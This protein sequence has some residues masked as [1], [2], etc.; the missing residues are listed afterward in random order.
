MKY[1]VTCTDFYLQVYSLAVKKCGLIAY[2][3]KR[4]LLADLNNGQPNPNTHA[5]GHYSQVNEVQVEDAEEQAA[6]GN[7]LHI[8]T[9]KQKHEARLQRKHAIALKRAKRGNIDDSSEDDEAE[10]GGDDLVVAQLAAAARPG[11][12]VR[13]NDVIEQICAR[14]NL[15]RPTSQPP[16]MPSE[17]AGMRYY[18]LTPQL[19]TYVSVITVQVRAERTGR[20]HHRRGSYRHREQV[21]RIEINALVL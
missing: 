17:R 19:F 18:G 12:S 8:I 11:T 16:F 5:C 20:H 2:N 21:S 1:Y 9:Q 7:D 3:D 6:A 14:Q 13:I 4:V 10:L 15:Q